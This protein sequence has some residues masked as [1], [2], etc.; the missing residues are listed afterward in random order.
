M[1][2]WYAKCGPET[3]R[4]W[5]LVTRDD[6][7]YWTPRSAHVQVERAHKWPASEHQDNACSRVIVQTRARH[8]C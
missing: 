5:V 6:G 4:E 7:Q 1:F 2:Q 8:R 3:V